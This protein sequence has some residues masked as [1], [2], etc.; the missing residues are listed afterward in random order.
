MKATHSFDFSPHAPTTPFTSEL[1][2]TNVQAGGLYL[3]LSPHPTA[4]LLPSFISSLKSTPSITLAVFL[5]SRH[6]NLHDCTALC[7]E[8]QGS[9][10]SP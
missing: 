7:S 8:V 5:S 3:P 2:L 4:N 6:G 10:A 1:R 9:T